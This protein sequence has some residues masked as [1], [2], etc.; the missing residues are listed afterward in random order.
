MK[1]NIYI[2]LISFLVFNLNLKAQKL[3]SPNDFLGYELGT[4]FTPHHKVVDYFKTV[5]AASPERVKLMHYGKTNEHRDL[6]IAVVSSPEN[7]KNLEEIKRQNLINAGLKPGD[8]QAPKTAI[9]WLSYNVHGNEASST[10]AAMKTIYSL[11]KEK[12]EWLKNTVVII[13]PCVNPD[14]RQR[15][16]S[17]YTQKG[18]L[19]YNV[20][21]QATEHNEPWPSGRPNHYLFDLNRDWMWATQVETQQR[22]K[23]YN[24]WMPHVHVDFHEQ[25]KDNNY[26]FAPAAKPYH[27]IITPWQRDFQTQ[28]GKNHAKYFDKEGWLYFTRERFDLFYPSYGDTYPTYMGAIGM[29]YE[30]AGHGRAGLGILTKEKDTLT[31]IDRIKHHTTTGL[32]T[33]E[34]AS[35]NAAKLNEEFKQF[36]QNNALETKSYVMRGNPEKLDRLTSLLDKHDIEYENASK[37]KVSGYHYAKG[38]AGSMQVDDNAVVVHTNQPKAKMVKV[39]FE[40]N[41][42][43]EDS[44]TYDITAWSLPYAYGL[45]AIASKSKV[46][47]VKQEQSKTEEIPTLQKSFA[48]ICEWDSMADAKFLSALI[49]NGIR[50]RFSKKP[51]TS[52]GNA[53]KAGAL[54]I[55][56]RDN[57]H[58]QDLSSHLAKLSKAYK[59]DL[60]SITSGF[61]DKTPDLGS[62]DIKLIHPPNIAVFSG[63][64]IS[65]LNYGEVWHF[66]EQQLNYPLTSINLESYTSLDL[67]PYD[68]IILPNGNYKHMLKADSLQKLN[69][70]VKEGGRLVAIQDALELFANSKAFKLKKKKQDSVVKKKEAEKNKT[71]AYALRERH[72]MSR[73]I[74]G[75]IFKAEVDH[76]HPMAFGYDKHY[77]TLKLSP[78]SYQLMDNAYNVG[79]IKDNNVYSGFAGH[80]AQKQIENTLVFGE[81][82]VGKGSVMYVVDNVLFRAFWENGKLFMANAVF[83][84]NNDGD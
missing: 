20:D 21:V 57:I 68:V 53:F 30:Q 13:D 28:I 15:Y 63:E 40:P 36:F 55:T 29:T 66:F 80:L 70:W 17:W 24:T 79:Y 18:R 43:L 50:L 65:S 19:P 45:E 62:S 8:S 52:N 41:A 84:V 3:Q 73:F 31:L 59:V 33:V 5:E 69:Q 9:V 42:K 32:S 78:S 25:G 38:S 61:S 22:L 1:R 72:N 7:I 49:Q 74:T 2:L 10:E 71:L 82:R 81:E 39:L 6:Y 16:V 51:F 35:K 46:K 27:E 64:N 60:M 75:A 4:R 44:L 26:Y 48:Y 58:L 34:I 54:I 37:Q 11:L 76:T 56:Q 67:D 12:Q 77:F 47:S 14:G 83:F 23:V